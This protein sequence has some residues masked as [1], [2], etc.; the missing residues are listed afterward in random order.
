VMITIGGPQS[1]WARQMASAARKAGMDVILVLEGEKPDEYQGNLLLDH[2]MGCEL[3][4]EKIDQEE[5]DREILGECPITG[6]V[7][8]EVKK[9]GR[10]PYAAPL[11]AATPLG[12]LG[13]INAVDELKEQ[14]DRMEVAADYIVLATGT[15]GTQAG[16][17]LGVRLLELETKV[18]GLSISRHTRDKEDEIAELCNRTMDFLELKDFTVDRK[19]IT[20][21]YDYIGEGYAVPTNECIDAIRTVARTEGIILDPVYTGKAMAGLIDLIRKQRFTRQENVVF[22]HTGGAT[23]N[24]AYKDLFR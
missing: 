8:E 15:G 16:V 11:G 10:I 21:N 7:A 22:I 18:I 5:E 2:I 4:F 3:R 23:A 24:F 17:E 20:V 6:R 1:N 13:Y 14:L 19:E 9:E 12:N